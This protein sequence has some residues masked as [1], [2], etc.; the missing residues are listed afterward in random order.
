MSTTQLLYAS[1]AFFLILNV[2]ASIMIFKEGIKKTHS[3][4][5]LLLLLIWLIPII[6]FLFMTRF[7]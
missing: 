3:Q 6:G 7:I 5:L 2:Y 1:L 4:K